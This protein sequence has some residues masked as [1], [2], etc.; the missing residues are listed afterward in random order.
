MKCSQ[1]TEGWVCNLEAGHSGPCPAWPTKLEQLPPLDPDTDVTTECLNIVEDLI[2]RHIQIHQ[3]ADNG[4]LKLAEVW[5]KHA[6]NNHISRNAK[7]WNPSGTGGLPAFD[8]WI[9]P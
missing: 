2:G 3:D 4:F 9:E 5:L 6:K 8:D 1:P 7:W